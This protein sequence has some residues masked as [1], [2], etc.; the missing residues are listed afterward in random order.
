MVQETVEKQI[1]PGV[2]LQQEIVVEPERETVV[3]N[4]DVGK[5]GILGFDIAVIMV[6]IS[7]LP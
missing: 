6:L 5:L 4:V 1:G 7:S 3:I 2:D